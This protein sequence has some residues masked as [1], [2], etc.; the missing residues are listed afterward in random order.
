MGRHRI[1]LIDD[2]PIVVQ[3]MKMLFDDKLCVTCAG[4]G[5]EG[6]RAVAEERPDIVLL[7]IQMEG[8]DGYETCRRMRLLELESQPY[9]IFVSAHGDPVRRLAAYNAGGEDFVGKPLQ[10]EELMRKVEQ[11]LRIRNEINALRSQTQG[12][13]SVAMSAMT[14]SS[15]LGICLQY[16]RRLFNV[17]GPEQLMEAS[18]DAIGEFGLNGAVQLRI[19]GETRTLNSERRSNPM[20]SLLLQDLSADRQRIVS[21]GTRTAFHYGQVSILI[22]NMPTDDLDRYGKL[23]DYL[24]LMTE[25]AA[26]RL[27][28]LAQ[29]GLAGMLD[30][31]RDSLDAINQRYQRQQR[32]ARALCGAMREEFEQALARL[33]LSETQQE[34]LLEIVGRTHR[35]VD[36]LYDGDLAL[37]EHLRALGERLGSPAA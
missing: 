25:G 2:D 18:L 27:H 37:D 7:D 6:L 24:A 9:V 21:C 15:A 11:A 34:A 5:D 8:M 1:L 36:A 10:P 13:M 12:A 31:A 14:D 3:V 35:A 26:E 22:K 30:F 19:G 32:D 29:E 28:S 4:S 20:E 33:G 23:K 16:F 17:S